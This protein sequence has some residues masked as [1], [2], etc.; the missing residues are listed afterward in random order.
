MKSYHKKE[1]EEE[2]EEE[3]EA[4][5]EGGES[6]RSSHHSQELTSKRP[7]LESHYYKIHI[8]FCDHYIVFR[9]QRGQRRR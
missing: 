5:V 9:R 1:R 8:I 2:R 6:R 7:K 3:K 4:V